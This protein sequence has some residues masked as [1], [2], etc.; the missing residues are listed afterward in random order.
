MSS[1]REML[2]SSVITLIY[3]SSPSLIGSN[4]CI[5]SVLVLYQAWSISMYLWNGTVRKDNYPIL[6]CMLYCLYWFRTDAWSEMQVSCTYEATVC[7]RLWALLI[8]LPW[9]ST[10]N[11][12]WSR[13]ASTGLPADKHS[14]WFPWL[15]MRI[16]LLRNVS[17]NIMAHR[18]PPV[19][20]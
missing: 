6:K 11:F 5:L 1:I 20:I 19:L 17:R 8:F 15:L 4:P 2:F 9:L 10:S 7:Q 16:S 18:S 14:I 12:F 3:I 13:V